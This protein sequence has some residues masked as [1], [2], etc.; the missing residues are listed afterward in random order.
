MV[1]L[2]FDCGTVTAGKSGKNFALLGGTE[3]T[4]R[5]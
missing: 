3:E 5:I 2:A 4:T 1:G